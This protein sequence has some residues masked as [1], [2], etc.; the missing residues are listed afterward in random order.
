MGRK[1]FTK[2]RKVKGEV[3]HLREQFRELRRTIRWYLYRLEEIPND[4]ENLHNIEIIRD[5]VIT[6][7]EFFDEVTQK[8]DK[9]RKYYVELNKEFWDKF[10]DKYFR[11]KQD[12]F[13]KK[14][15]ELN[16]KIDNVEPIHFD[17]KRLLIVNPTEENKLRVM[18]YI[19]DNDNVMIIVTNGD[20]YTF[21]KEIS[22]EIGN[23]FELIKKIR[24]TI[25]AKPDKTFIVESLPNDTVLM[26]LVNF[27]RDRD[28]KVVVLYNHNDFVKKLISENDFVGGL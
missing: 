28:T 21:D 26:S 17:G 23:T 7:L 10:T 27:L 13:K 20:I 4:C 19:R 15:D 9:L 3:D 22:N 24:S 2:I 25:L 1:K 12:C 16:M 14:I 18:K 8:L 6:E 11:I 5:N